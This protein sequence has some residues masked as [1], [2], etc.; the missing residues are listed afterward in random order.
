[1]IKKTTKNMSYQESDE[2]TNV[3][4]RALGSSYLKFQATEISYSDI[5]IDKAINTVHKLRPLIVN[6][7]ALVTIVTIVTLG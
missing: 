7:R 1:M 6:N 5:N 2:L 4:K 3:I